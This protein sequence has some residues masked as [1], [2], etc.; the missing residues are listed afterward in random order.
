[1]LDVSARIKLLKTEEGG[2]TSFVRSGYRPTL[3]FGHLYTDGAL[4]FL[5]RQQVYPGDA[6]EVHLI[7]THPDYVREY[8]VAGAYFDIMEGS[9]KIGDGTLLAIPAIL[10]GKEAGV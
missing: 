1:M 10:Q 9:R 2:R 8:L 6:C 5:G 7:L 4:T 3:R